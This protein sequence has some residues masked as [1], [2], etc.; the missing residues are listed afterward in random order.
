MAQNVTAQ[1]FLISE[2]PCL[3]WSNKKENSTRKKKIRK[4]VWD[5][6]HFCRWHSCKGCH[7]LPWFWGRAR[8]L[9]TTW[10]TDGVEM[11]PR[12]DWP[13]VCF[14]ASRRVARLQT[15]FWISH[16]A[17]SASSVCDAQAMCSRR[18]PATNRSWLSA[19][20]VCGRHLEASVGPR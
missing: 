18:V 20:G 9:Q 17:L 14:L 19:V 16:G 7:G 1:S 3:R 2:I 5:R 12:D 4:G 10:I 13:K 15:S 11:V 8:L 6:S